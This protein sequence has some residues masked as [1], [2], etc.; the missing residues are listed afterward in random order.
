MLLMWNAENANADSQ[1]GL[2]YKPNSRVPNNYID[3]EFS[4]KVIGTPASNDPERLY[5]LR[6]TENTKRKTR[7][8]SKYKKLSEQVEL[9][10]K[11]LK[12]FKFFKKTFYRYKDKTTGMDKASKEKALEAELTKAL[13]LWIR[14]ENEDLD[15]AKKMAIKLSNDLIKL[16]RNHAKEKSRQLLTLKLQNNLKKSELALKQV[17]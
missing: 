14:K 8:D 9:D 5:F 1:R 16:E 7:Q 12:L 4:S 15:V 11:Y 13:N 10:S 2:G 6:K 17:S 3:D